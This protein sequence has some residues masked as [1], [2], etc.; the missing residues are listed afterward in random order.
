MDLVAEG[1]ARGTWD[2]LFKLVLLEG[3]TVRMIRVWVFSESMTIQI[4]SFR[5]AQCHALAIS[6]REN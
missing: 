5:M 3:N 4:T 2:P 1:L 6:Y